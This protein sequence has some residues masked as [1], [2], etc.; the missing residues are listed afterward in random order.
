MAESR[1]VARQAAAAVN[2]TYDELP[3]IIA[4][5]VTSVLADGLMCNTVRCLQFL[6][7]VFYGISVSLSVLFCAVDFLPTWQIKWSRCQDSRR[8][9]F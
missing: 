9:R 1:D 8:S 7:L 5:E 6:V 3:A 2:V 4:I